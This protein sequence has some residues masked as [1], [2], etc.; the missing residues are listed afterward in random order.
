MKKMI[1]KRGKDRK[2][3]EH[4]DPFVSIALSEVTYLF[5]APPR[6]SSPDHP[7]LG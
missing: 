6:L 5:I 1:I 3:E 7:A 4:S 2:E